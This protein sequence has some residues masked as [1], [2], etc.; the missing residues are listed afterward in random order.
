MSKSTTSAP[1][2]RIADVERANPL[3]SHQQTIAWQ[4]A[5]ATQRALLELSY[6]H[7]QFVLPSYE[8]VRRAWLAL[9]E[10]ER[11]IAPLFEEA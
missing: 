9:V 11:E 8:P 7:E 2:R 5:R 4:A 6:A 10:L 1:V 3:W